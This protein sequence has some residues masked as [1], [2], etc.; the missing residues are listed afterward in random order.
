[1]ITNGIDLKKK[2]ETY[3]KL[4]AIDKEI[5]RST[6]YHSS[7]FLLRARA[8]EEQM[9]GEKSESCPSGG[10]T[11]FQAFSGGLESLGGK[12]VKNCGNCGKPINAFISKGYKC[13]C[14]GVFEG[15]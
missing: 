12:F 2:S 13:S 9:I 6:P 10:Q 3:I 1:M 11:V 14:G 5:Y 15:C 8:D 7:Y 4:G